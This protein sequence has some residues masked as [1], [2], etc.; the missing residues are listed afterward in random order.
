MLLY[1]HLGASLGGSPVPERIHL[2]EPSV[3]WRWYSESRTAAGDTDC[4][5]PHGDN[6]GG[7]FGLV[8]S[9][10]CGFESSQGDLEVRIRSLFTCQGCRTPTQCIGFYKEFASERSY[11]KL[12]ETLCFPFDFKIL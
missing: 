12:F 7:R 5:R 8:C 10:R 6:S 1:S 11:L 3:P 2:D 9:A 4:E